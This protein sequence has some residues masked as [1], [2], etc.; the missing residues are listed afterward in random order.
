[1][2]RGGG[3][4]GGGR[5]G[6]CSGMQISPWGLPHTGPSIVL[7]LATSEFPTQPRPALSP[8]PSSI[9]P[10]PSSLLSPP[11]LNT[12]NFVVVPL[13]SLDGVVAA[14]WLKSLRNVPKV[15]C[16]RWSIAAKVLC[17]LAPFG[18]SNE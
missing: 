7:G 1:V 9:F 13:F 2:R 10:P 3:G 18:A 17:L 8:P 14:S 6:G 4:E 16:L 5:E 11:Q 12:V 15:V